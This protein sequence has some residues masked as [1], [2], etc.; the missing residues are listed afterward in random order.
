MNL[1]YIA[2]LLVE[3]TRLVNESNKIMTR[4]DNRIRRDVVP[5]LK[6]QAPV[7][8]QDADE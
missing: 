1:R 5:A 8:Q 6:A 7:Q 4:M 3:L 2:T